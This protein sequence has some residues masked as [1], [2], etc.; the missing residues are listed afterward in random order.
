MSVW[1]SHPLWSS[2]RTSTP[3]GPERRLN[4]RTLGRS[5]IGK[6]VMTLLIVQ[7]PESWALS[8]GSSRC[9]TWPIYSFLGILPSHHQEFWCP[10]SQREPLFHAL[11]P[12]TEQI[13]R[14]GDI[15]LK[16][17]WLPRASHEEVSN[18]TFV[19]LRWVCSACPLPPW[20]T[21][22]PWSNGKHCGLEFPWPGVN[23]GLLAV[24]APSSQV[25]WL[26]S[27]P[28][29]GDHVPAQSGMGQAAS[30]GNQ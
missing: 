20:S 27:F 5:I 22:L 3:L 26:C 18:K 11:R 21:F 16:K 13:F 15:W 19:R 14:P 30:L 1:H 8:M 4:N 28:Q 24:P 9:T 25:L 23:P 12:P 7:E 29:S 10:E 2:P 6:E 17:P